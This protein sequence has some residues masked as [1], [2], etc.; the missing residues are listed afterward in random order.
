MKVHKVHEVELKDYILAKEKQAPIIVKCYYYNTLIEGSCRLSRSHVLHK[1][2]YIPKLSASKP[3]SSDAHFCLDTNPI[4]GDIPFE[5][6][7]YI[8]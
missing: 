8:Q 3:R 4:S 6:D 1:Y 5:S 7:I 2:M